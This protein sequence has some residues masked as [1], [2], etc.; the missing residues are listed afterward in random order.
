MVIFSYEQARMK[1]KVKVKVRVIV[2]EITLITL[3]AE[4]DKIAKQK[5]IL[6][7]NEALLKML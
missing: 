4:Y 7:S 1:V 3:E 6:P 5:S 2:K